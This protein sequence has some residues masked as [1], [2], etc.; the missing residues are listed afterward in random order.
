MD[1]KQG[2]I[3]LYEPPQQSLSEQAALLVTSGSEQAGMRPYIIVSRELVHKNK[4]TVVGVPL[5]TR[6][7]KA[8]SYRIM[9][10]S[11]ELIPVPGRPPFSDS[12]A[13]CD[14]VRVLDVGQIRYKV[15]RLSDNAVIGVGLG[16]AFV[17]DLR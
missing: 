6:V 16:L 3:C 9:L 11:P 17:F 15:G 5:T 12:V 13:F 8:N 7:Q 4:P 2:D 10:P 14:H 1:L